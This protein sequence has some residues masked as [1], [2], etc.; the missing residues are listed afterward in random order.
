MNENSDRKNAFFSAIAKQDFDRARFKGFRNDVLSWL[1]QRSNHLLPFDEVRKRLPVQGQHYIGL[2]E[3][4]LD[5]VIGSVNRYQ[6]FDRAFLP[7]QTFTRDRWMSVDIAHL[8]DVVLPPI[9]LYKVGET[10]YVKD[11]NHR[12]SVAR[13]KGQS[14]I[15]AVVIEID[16]PV[17]VTTDTELSDLIRKQ[18]QAN[19]LLYTHI[20]DLR[21]DANIEFSQPGDYDRLL[22]H[23]SVHRWYL[24]VQRNGEVPYEEAVTSWYDNVYLPLVS[25]IRERN[26]LREFPGRTETDLYLWIIEHQRYLEEAHEDK[27]SLAEAADHYARKYS[28]R[29]LKRLGKF[30]RRAVRRV[31]TGDETQEAEAGREQ[32]EEDG[33]APGEGEG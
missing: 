19:F 15:D 1:T 14:F 9:E 20:Q 29:P 32:G 26:I 2:K 30:F 17:P 22:E 13:E 16:V 33:E 31:S 24:G 21:P 23:I 12:V 28:Q 6:D 27:V 11:G 5:Q 7:R 18:E 10:Y 8:E 4:P 3:V 25:I